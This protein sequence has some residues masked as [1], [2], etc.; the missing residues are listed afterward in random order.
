[1]LY[2]RN[3]HLKQQYSGCGRI[4]VEPVTVRGRKADQIRQHVATR[5]IAP[6]RAAGRERVDIKIGDVQA[7]LQSTMKLALICS[8]LR[9]AKFRQDHNLE[10]VRE[11]DAYYECS[12]TTF[13]FK[14]L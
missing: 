11:T 6:A 2:G 5:Y 1:M 3:V 7:E 9:A 12:S 4:I 8:S 13:T 10:L 14:L